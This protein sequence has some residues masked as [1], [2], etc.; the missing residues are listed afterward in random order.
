[1][2]WQTRD[3]QVRWREKIAITAPW[4]IE[5]PINDKGNL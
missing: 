4:L 2:E 1:M 3:L 5:V